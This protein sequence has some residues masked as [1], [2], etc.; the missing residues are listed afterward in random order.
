MPR[1]ARRAPPG[2]VALQEGRLDQRRNQKRA[3][4]HARQIVVRV[5]VDHVE[6]MR[7][8]VERQ[9]QKREGG[10]IVERFEMVKREVDIIRNLL[11]WNGIA[12]I[13]ITDS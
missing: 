5:D 13:G 3:G 2:A 8:L 12:P 6:L 1:R 9:F 10:C 11:Y 4:A 7:E